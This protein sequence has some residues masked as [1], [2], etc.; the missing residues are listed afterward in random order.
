MPKTAYSTQFRR[1]VDVVQLLALVNGIQPDQLD[2]RAEVPAEI[3]A[4][5]RSDVACSSCGVAGAQIVRPATG[6]KG[7]T[8]RQAHFR[9]A[10][11][12]G[13]DMHHP[14]CEFSGEDSLVKR[15]ND[16]LIDFGAAKTSETEQI[17]LLVCK[18]IT[19]KDFDQSTIRAMRQWF[20]DLKVSHRFEVTATPAIFD[21]ML[22]LARYSFVSFP[23]DFSPE[24][25]DLPDYEWREAAKGIFAAE[26]KDLL[27]AIRG[28]HPLVVRRGK[29]L[30][31]QHF[32]QEEFKPAV[33]EPYY[34]AALNLATFLSVNGGIP[35]G[36]IKPMAYRWQGASGPLLALSALLLFAS[37]WNEAAA[38]RM[39]VAILASPTP[40]DL[41]LGNV[42]GLNPFHDYPAWKAVQLASSIP[43][44]RPGGFDFFAELRA[45]ELK[46][47]EVH[48]A[49]RQSGL[50]PSVPG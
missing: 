22:A 1:E 47:R 26:N 23:W 29:A 49:W 11:E 50:G 30:A 42:I 36:K 39:F 28:L 5:V 8:L 16:H 40:P 6:T 35:W 21:W 17:R 20:F 32:G 14:F 25:G 34:V 3:K 33:L 37:D 46:L 19:R 41:T 13:A 45:I 27:T 12:T 9:F 48:R 7:Q 15:R 10:S 38:I 2:P 4:L 31:A 43:A 24:Y 18:G 44:D